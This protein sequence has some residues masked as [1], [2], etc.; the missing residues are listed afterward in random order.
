M[1]RNDDD[2]F[3]DKANQHKDWLDK[4]IRDTK[5]LTEPTYIKCREKRSLISKAAP[6][7]IEPEINVSGMGIIYRCT[8]K[9]VV[10]AA[11]YIPDQLAGFDVK[12]DELHSQGLEIITAS[13]LAYARMNSSLERLISVKGTFI[14]E[15]VLYA[16]E[17][18][19][20][21]RI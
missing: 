16:P 15:G 17:G 5:W 1:A 20:K 12:V 9:Q 2:W 19:G 3:E 7:K 21:H 6:I 10:Y 11:S 4:A 18:M 14:K 8:G 13:Q